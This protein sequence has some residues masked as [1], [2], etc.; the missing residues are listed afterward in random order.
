MKSKSVTLVFDRKKNSS[1]YGTGKIEVRIGL[2][3]TCRKT[4]VVGETTPAEWPAIS[5]GTEM[6]NIVAKYERVVEA[7]RYLNEEMTLENF[8]KHLG[9][10]EKP[11]KKTDVDSVDF[12]AFM[13]DAVNKEKLANGTLKHKR[14]VIES[15]K[16]FGKIQKVS[17][18]TPENIRKYNEWL[19]E[20]GER[21]DIT[22]FGY[23]KMVHKYVRQV[24]QRKYIDRDPY[25]SVELAHGKSKERQPLSE[26]EL[27]LMRSLRLPAKEAKARDLFIFSAYTGL[28]Y[29]DMQA[30]DFRT[31]T[32]K[33]GDLYYIDGSRIKTDTKFFTPIL[34]PA[35]EVLKKY[36]FNL[37]R[38]SNQ[39][40]NDY[41]HL[42]ESRMCL[43]K[44]LTFHVARHSF[45]TLSLAHDIPIENVARMLGHTDIRTTQIHAKILKTSIERHAES[46]ARAIS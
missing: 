16:M 1:I 33:H 24:Y 38:I 6:R 25:E 17:D 13:T 37:P 34:A 28:A 23:H 41:L 29:C 5:N 8:N 10:E 36:N 15:L 43:N 26:E 27:K 21:T 39:K 35:M 46:L 14:V 12:I 45:A 4:I 20:T 31:M 42:V 3:R 2:S 32:E 22:V 18:L 30:F 19:H 7:M 44:P 40:V 9:I 11:S